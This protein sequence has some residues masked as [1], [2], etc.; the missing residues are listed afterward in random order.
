[1]TVETLAVASSST[2]LRTTKVVA[3]T[4]VKAARGTTELVTTAVPRHLSDSSLTC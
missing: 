1:M 2:A 4:T 3:E